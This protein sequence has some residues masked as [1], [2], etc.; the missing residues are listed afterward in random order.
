MTAVLGLDLAVS[1]SGVACADGTLHAV[2]PIAGP[3]D[4][5]RRLHQILH[6]L[7]P[8]IARGRPQLAVIEG[9]AGVRFA[10]SAL[11]LGEVR[12]AVK[13][14]LFEHDVPFVEVPPK[15]L[16]KWATGNGSA[17]KD[18]M[19]GAA[20]ARGARVGTNQH[21]EADA[22]LLRALGMAF[23]GA[24]RRAVEQASDARVLAWLRGEG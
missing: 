16:K 12:G 1:R 7:D 8:L 5:G 21:D 4:P 14:R 22:F 10:G 19:V 17:S 15:A 6:A 13:A 9:A 20:Q 18:D 3:D 11:V 23:A 24:H 2:T